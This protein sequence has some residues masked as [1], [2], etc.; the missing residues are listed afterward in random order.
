MAYHGWEVFDPA[1]IAEYTKWEVIQALPAPQAGVYIGKGLELVTGVLL[2][3][4]LFTRVAALLMAVNMLVICFK[5][6]NGRF[7]YEDQHPFVFAM[8][9]LVFFFAGPVKWSLDH[10]R[11]KKV[12]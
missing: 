8:V 3:L 11:A 5:I 6:G 2:T 7:W 9:A 1:K 10:R 4:G 12:S